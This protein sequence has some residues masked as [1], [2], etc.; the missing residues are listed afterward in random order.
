M[1]IKVTLEFANAADLVAYFSATALPVEG[2]PVPAN[3]AERKKKKDSQ[4]EVEQN[5]G[6]GASVSLVESG[7]VTQPSTEGAT[8]VV[9]GVAT[10][11]ASSEVQADAAAA[12]SATIEQVRAT[13]ARINETYGILKAKELLTMHGASRISELKPEQYGS[14]VAAAEKV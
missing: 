5:T 7:S 8:V 13:L 14:F 3:R 1:T 6:S 11:V 10:T 4:P 12:P 9:E 2:M